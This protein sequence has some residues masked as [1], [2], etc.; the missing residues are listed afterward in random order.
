MSRAKR[1]GPFADSDSEDHDSSSHSSARKRRRGSTGSAIPSSPPTDGDR[2][3][4]ATTPPSD[5]DSDEDNANGTPEATQ[6]VDR[7]RPEDNEPAEYGI[8]EAVHVV[9]FMC[10]KNEKWKLSPLI[11]FMCGK[12]GSGKSAI[13][14]AIVICLGGKASGTGRGSSLKD[15]VRHGANS[16]SVTCY[17]KN[18]GQNA[19]RNDEYGNTIAVER[20]FTSSGSSSFK[21][22]NVDGRVMSTKKGDLEEILDHFCLQMENPLN[23]LSQDMARSFIAS[24]NAS[25]KYKFF[26]KGVLLEQ[27]DQDYKIIEENIDNMTPKIT[28]GQEDL[29]EKKRRWQLADRKL[30]ESRKLD[31]TRERLAVLRHQCIW[32]QVVDL[33]VHRQRVS[34]AL[35]ENRG[36]IDVER[37]NAERLGEAYDQA[38][39]LVQQRK[40]EYDAELPKIEEARSDR[41]GAAEKVKET[42]D[43]HA[44]ARAE[45]RL[46]KDELNS[47]RRAVQRKEEEILNE[48]AR[49]TEVDGGGRARRLREL[50]D[51]RTAAE[52]ANTAYETRAASRQQYTAACDTAKEKV[53]AAEEEFKTQQKRLTDRKAELQNIRSSENDQG[54]KFH[55]RMPELLRA[56][57]KETRF[58][59]RPIGPIGKHIKLKHQNWARVL[60]KV[61][62]KT[63]NSFIVTNKHDQDILHELQRKYRVDGTLFMPPSY[64]LDVRAKEPDDEFLTI[65]R[66]LE[67][68]NF[69]VRN[70]LIMQHSIETAVLEENFDEACRIMNIRDPNQR[71]R[72][73]LNCFTLAHNNPSRGFRLF[74]R[75]GRPAQ[76]PVDEFVG[77][78]RL[79]SNLDEQVR[80]HQQY[81]SDEEH[82]LTHLK[83]EVQS[84]KH[85]YNAAVR[86]LKEYNEE[87]GRLRVAKQE[88][89]QKVEDKQSETEQ[90]NVAGGALDA[91]RQALEE[92]RKA[93]ATKSALFGDAVVA[94]DR[95]RKANEAAQQELTAMEDR[96]K[97]AQANADK[98]KSEWRRADQS[99]SDALAQKNWSLNKI[100][101]AERELQTYIQQ[102]ATADED[103]RKDTEQARASGSERVP[104][105]EGETAKT[106]DKKWERLLEQVTAANERVGGDPEE[107]E[108]QAADALQ[109]F[110][111]SKE[112]LE[113]MVTLQ[114]TLKASVHE[115]MRRWRFFRQQIGRSARSAFMYL[116]SE[117]G[118]RGKLIIDHTQHLLDL[119]VEPDIT[120]RDGTGRSARTLSGGEKSFSQICLLLALWEAMGS[121]VRCLDEFDVFMDAVNRN[122]SVNLL[123]EA[124]RQS[125]GRQYVLISPGTKSDI[126]PAP[127]VHAFEVA[128]PE[129]G[130]QRLSF[131]RAEAV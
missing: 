22:R 123:I 26:L 121:P 109:Q 30:K 72:N 8:L 48:E 36:K 65:M 94:E 70:V 43:T 113:G 55:E 16:A 69:L 112:D 118:F 58:R 122:L 74:Y 116:L 89:D 114:D 92:A 115:R 80:L 15:F 18:Q 3:S 96:L 125:R 9:N 28:Q 52:Q 57:G 24:S 40:Q 31:G 73:V 42:K 91:L 87:V 44:T 127:D 66:A 68:D 62:G 56:I 33:E 50:D 5:I 45:S 17:L 126:K 46:V 23:V 14:T 90:D 103:I 110:R 39:E 120:R 124:A 111:Q 51:L 2:Q 53:H 20:N 4:P 60:E 75:Q 108:R 41:N 97:E 76:D 101:D 130:Q 93:V 47:A 38:E 37:Q 21:I 85:E 63:P 95:D 19:F 32:A 117:R 102:L 27:L 82:R 78:L 29:A 54:R 64:E 1:P 11:N 61:F 86:A 10:H 106:L 84:C 98:A 71:P 100:E 119:L 105:P 131:Q 99:K 12:N 79:N 7:I 77:P 107:I 25:A 83:S 128:P 49:L 81:V 104:I 59:N 6:Q 35:D 67:I 129:R 34:D 88:A 13:L